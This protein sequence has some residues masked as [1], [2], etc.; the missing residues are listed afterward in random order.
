[1]HLVGLEGEFIYKFEDG[2]EMSLT[3]GSYIFVPESKVH[4]ER[5]GGRRRFVLSVHGEAVRDAYGYGS[6][7]ITPGK[8]AEH[9]RSDALPMKPGGCSS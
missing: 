2:P 1:M 9:H 3:P 5:C 6:K 4:S 7:V 8:D